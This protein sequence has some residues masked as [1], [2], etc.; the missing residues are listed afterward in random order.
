MSIN[1]AEHQARNQEFFRTGEFYCN[2]V[3][4]I[5][6]P[7]TTHERKTPQEKKLDFFLLETLK[8]IF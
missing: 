2:E 7:P 8:T 3:T 1:Y 4:S 5:N 6:I